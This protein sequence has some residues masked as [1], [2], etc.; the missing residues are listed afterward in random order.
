[1][2]KWVNY[3]FISSS[4][5][6]PE[7]KAF[8]SD[9]KKFI[10]KNLPSGCNLIKFNRGHFYVSG[11]IQKQDKYIY[12]SIPDVRCSKWHRDI[13]IRTAKNDEDYLGGPNHFT[14]IDN[15]KHDVENLIQ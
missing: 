9:F 8:A 1:M 5:T 13:L 12:F 4:Q 15:F 10:K 6:T 14:D 7:F 11:F 3:D 2:K